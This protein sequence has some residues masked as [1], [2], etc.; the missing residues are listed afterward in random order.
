MSRATQEPSQHS[1]GPVLP[2]ATRWYL[3]NLFTFHVLFVRQQLLTL[4][5]KYSVTD[6]IGR[7]RFF[8]VRPPKLFLSSLATMARFAVM[9][10]A[11]FYA[12][13]LF[14]VTQDIVLPFLLLFTVRMLGWLI[15]VLL[16]PYRD[17]RV[18]TDSSE[19]F[20]TLMI[21]QDNKFGLH[22]WFTIFDAVGVPVARA[23]RHFIKSLWRRQWVAETLDGREICRVRE[24]S[25]PL[26]LMRRYLG[27]LWGLLRTN[28]DIVF[29]TGQHAGEYNRKL[30]ITDQYVLD[31]RDD[32]NLLIDRRVALSLAILLDTAEYR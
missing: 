27:T 29:P 22:S 1:P 32:P 14:M 20:Q 17:I 2:P 30:T 9:V 13:R 7:D 3:E 25:L 18:F 15:R 12:M 19:Q 31:L 4:A 5:Q 8:V 6:E 16:T 11:L 23:R 10:L 24:D 28:F 26:A 21:S